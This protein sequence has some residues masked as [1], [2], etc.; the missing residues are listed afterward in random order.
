MINSV[1]ILYKVLVSWR[2]EQIFG[3]H[4]H[5]FFEDSIFSLKQGTRSI[6]PTI[7]KSHYRSHYHYLFFHHAEIHHKS[8]SCLLKQHKTVNNQRISL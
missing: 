5:Q 6:Q 8:M 7:S 4:C 2:S 1:Q 3:V